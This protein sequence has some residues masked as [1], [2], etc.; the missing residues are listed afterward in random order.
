MFVGKNSCYIC[1]LLGT[2]TKSKSMKTTQKTYYNQQTIQFLREKYGFKPNYIRASIRG[3]RK[4][5]IP[6]KIKKEYERI[7]KQV[8]ETIRKNKDV[9]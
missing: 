3:D 1:T 9:I 4:G 6:T 7:E 8:A 2:D 5:I